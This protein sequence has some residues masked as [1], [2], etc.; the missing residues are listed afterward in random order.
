MGRIP[1]QPERERK[2]YTLVL[3]TSNGYLDTTQLL[4]IPNT[5]GTHAPSLRLYLEQGTYITKI[6]HH[7][8]SQSINQLSPTITGRSSDAM[9]LQLT[10][11]R[12]TS[13]RTSGELVLEGQWLLILGRR[14]LDCI[15]ESRYLPRYGT[16]DIQTKTKARPS[17]PENKRHARE[18]SKSGE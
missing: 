4:I 10:H 2:P 6:C 1:T 12:H 14:H 5:L 7:I 11:L 13:H 9:A 3:T 18:P 16:T 15:I 17:Q 8:I